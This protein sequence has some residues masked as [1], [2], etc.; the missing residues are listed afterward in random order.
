MPNPPDG[1][2][3][4]YTLKADA[5]GPVTLEILDASGKTLRRYASTDRP[6][7]VPDAATAA[8]PLYWYRS[9]RALPASAGMHRVTWDMRYDALPGG[10]GGRGGL[11]IAAV[12]YN[13]GPA[14]T[15][16]WVAPGTYTVKLTVDGKSYTQPIVVKMDPRVRTSAI[17]LQQQATLSKALYDGALAAQAA[18][19]QLRGL[20]EQAE[21]AGA[22]TTDAAAKTAVEAFV[23]KVVALGGA[24]PAA[25]GGGRGGGAGGGGGRGGGG[26]PAPDSFAN[27]GA[28]FSSLIS[29]LQAADA[30]PTAAVVAAVTERQAALAKL[31]SEMAA[32]K[33]TDLAA[34][35]AALTR[36]G[37]PA[38]VMK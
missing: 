16:P 31:T 11:P 20:R 15:A 13:T 6:E 14:A 32:L 37:Q 5:K 34:V 27:I 29:A 33:T 24:A 8:V 28:T 23:K 3:I 17:G 10:G 36:A 38:I 22:K 2:M 12:P 35:N 4:D 1:A 7:T 26:A 21:A 19:E 25:G 9:G 18:V 30:T